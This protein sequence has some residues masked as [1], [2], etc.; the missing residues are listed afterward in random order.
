MGWGDELIATGQA[1]VLQQTNPGK[2][3]I[4]DRHGAQREH[5]MWRGNPRIATRSDRLHK[6][7]FLA[8]GPGVRPYI[9]AKTGR[10]WSWREFECPV[11][12]IYFS[13]D[14]KNF[15][16][17]FSPGVILEPNNKAKASPNKDWGFSNWQ[18]LVELMLGA[19][20][21]PW[22]LGPPG[23]RVLAGAKIIHTPSFRHGCAVLAR[24]KACVLPEGG[25]HHAAAAVCVPAV[26]IYGGFIS[27]KQTGYA[28]QVNLF[29]GGEPCGM[30]IP[31]EHCKRAMVAITPTMVLEE[32]QRII[33]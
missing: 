16:A 3:V 20:I 33:R 13:E 21:R 4:Q 23:T 7:Q 2:V 28:S 5:E 30:R 29:T 14:E 9:V 12:E 10:Q 25:L 18:R 8:N 32:L 22:Q 31:C 24:A 27:P 17:Q 6:P 15:A 26:V 1:R 19:G 11:G